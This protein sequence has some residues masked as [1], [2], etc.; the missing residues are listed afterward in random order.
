M[1]R[2]ELDALLHG[3]APAVRDFVVASQQALHD[4]LAAVEAREPVPG[5]PG[6]PGVKGLDGAP[7]VGF[8]DLDVSVD[9]DRTLVFRFAKGDQEKTF[10]VV[11]G[12]PV[13]QKNWIL[14]KAYVPGDVVTWDGSEWACLEATDDGQPGV[15]KSWYRSVTKGARGKDGLDGKDWSP[16]PVVRVGAVK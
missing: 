13:Y 4:R 1:T 15:S 14:G 11:V 12:W 5:P 6:P 9:G 8:E 2:P 10:R 7:G 16:P 3:L